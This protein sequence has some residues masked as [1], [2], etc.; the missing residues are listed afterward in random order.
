[1]PNTTV[2]AAGGALPAASQDNAPT[3][4]E[5]DVSPAMAAAIKRHRVALAARTDNWWRNDAL[6]PEYRSDTPENNSRIFEALAE[7]D[8]NSLMNLMTMRPASMA[9]VRVRC[10]YLA[11]YSMHD[12]MTVEHWRA[13]MISMA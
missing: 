5:P 4:A 11:E 13:L 7:E 12:D 8:E 2:S 9:D 6:A 3:H 10:A 1:M